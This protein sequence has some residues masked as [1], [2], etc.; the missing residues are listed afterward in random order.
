MWSKEGHA[1]SNCRARGSADQVR[2]ASINPADW[3]IRQGM[4]KSAL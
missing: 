4:L 2:A 1:E 3:K